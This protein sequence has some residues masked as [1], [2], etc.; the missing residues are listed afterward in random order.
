V[1]G[2]SDKITIGIVDYDVGNHASVWRVLHMLGYRCRVS[3]DPKALAVSD[4]LVL[5]GVGAFP[6][7]MAS[8]T[9]YGLDEF[10]R[11]SAR[12]GTPFLGVCLGMQLL[13]DE[14]DEHSVTSGLGLIPGRV[15]PIG[16]GQWHIGWNS[17]ELEN[18]DPMFKASDGQIMYFNHSFHF[19]CA[20]E[21]RVATSTLKEKHA[22]IIRRDNVVGIQFHP[23]KSQVPGH[24]LLKAV[25][26][27]LCRA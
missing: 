8:L 17:I 9:Q 25:V 20:P 5:P 26:E 1:S 4:M 6:K 19:Q 15:V 18:Q 11:D 10:L 12:S 7:A 27:G 13:A 2:I 3:K 14:S 22:A 16:P 24:A 23:E 21:F